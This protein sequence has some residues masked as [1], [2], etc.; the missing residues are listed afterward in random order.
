MIKYTVDRVEGNLVVLLK[1]GNE[2]VV[3]DVA[4]DCFP[5]EIKVGDIVEETETNGDFQYNILDSETEQRRQKADAL[6]SRLKK[7]K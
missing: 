5:K 1:K 6:L 4:I 7:N 2:S 3:K